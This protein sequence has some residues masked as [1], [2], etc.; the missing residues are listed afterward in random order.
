MVTRDRLIAFF[1]AAFAL[2]LVLKA[3]YDHWPKSGRP[4]HRE[5]T[6]PVV[7]VQPAPVPAPGVPTPATKT[8]APKKK[9]VVKPKPK[10]KRIIRECDEFGWCWTHVG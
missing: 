10:P 4:R 1:L 5:P 9:P 6:P 8:P 7:S 2:A 3:G